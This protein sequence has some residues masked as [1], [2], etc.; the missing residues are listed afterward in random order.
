[1]LRWSGGAHDLAYA[2]TIVIPAAV[3]EY[4]VEPAGD[5]PVRLVRAFV[6]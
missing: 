2:E 4:T 5:T 6:T 1:V 3:G